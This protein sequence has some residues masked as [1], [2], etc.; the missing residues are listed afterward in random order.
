LTTQGH[1][2]KKGIILKRLILDTE[3]I[4][5]DPAVI[6]RLQLARHTKHLSHI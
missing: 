2:V 6:K 5:N 4:K 1:S 3:L